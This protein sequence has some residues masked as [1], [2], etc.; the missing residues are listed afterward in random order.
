MPEK[1]EDTPKFTDPY[2]NASEPAEEV[3]QTVSGGKAAEAAPA[4]SGQPQPL[5]VGYG[6]PGIPGGVPAKE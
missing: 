4:V 5:G 1:A 6:M 3:V 2:H